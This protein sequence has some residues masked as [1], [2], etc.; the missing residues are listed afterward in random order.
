MGKRFLSLL[1]AGLLT[2]T[3]GCGQQSAPVEE[4]PDAP[5]IREP[6]EPVDPRTLEWS[7]PEEYLDLLIVDTE[8]GDADEH[9]VSLLTVHEK[10]SVEA[11]EAEWGD[12]A[13]TGFLF[14]LCA[15]DQIAF[16]QF[17]QY[18]MAG[19][20]VFAKG[21]GWYYAKTF[22]TD[23]QY[24]RAGRELDTK[25]EDWATWTELNA[26][27]ETVCQDFLTRNG[28]EAFTALDLQT[29]SFTWEGEH[30]YAQYYE[31]YGVDGSRDE[32]CTLLLSQPVKQGEGGIWCVDRTYDLYGYQ[33]LNFGPEDVA[34]ADYYEALQAECDAG[35]HPELLTPLGAARAYVTETSWLSGEATDENLILV[36]RLDTEYIEVNQKI[37]QL[38]AALMWRPEEV[39]EQEIL[40][41]IGSF[42]SDT[43]GVMGR[44]NYGPDWW[45]PLQEALERVAVGDVQAERDIAMMHIFLT[46]YGLYAKFI[47]Q[48]LLAQRDADP[49]AFLTALKD[50]NPQYQVAILAAVE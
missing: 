26:L 14:G 9:W 21:G 43:W 31:Y 49:D 27:G 30:A 45:G 25:S 23:V 44:R 47:G 6:T 17:L 37:S 15:L 19:T 22:A 29:A 39:S 32:F 12:G 34:A 48:Q 42:R 20:F 35:L 24:Y 36:D 7:I 16:E 5:E 13:G 46:A 10:A 1:L 41:T 28:L 8:P 18:D 50:F 38:L 3:V 2:L 40:D 33:Y 11:A 4:S